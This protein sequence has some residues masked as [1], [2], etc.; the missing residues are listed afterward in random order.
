[1]FINIKKIFV[2]LLFFAL[3]G[4]TNAKDDSSPKRVTLKE[5]TFEVAQKNKN[6]IIKG[7]KIYNQEQ[8][9]HF[10]KNYTLKKGASVRVVIFNE[11][12]IPTIIDLQTTNLGKIIYD[13]NYK[14]GDTENE[15]AVSNQSYNRLIK[16][17]EDNTVTYYLENQNEK[18]EIIKYNE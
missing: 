8:L 13:A 2:I 9:D 10:Y 15:Y 6:T 17:E 7:G 12:N 14:D 4:C 5:Y 18:K 1:M 3:V 11:Q 16:N